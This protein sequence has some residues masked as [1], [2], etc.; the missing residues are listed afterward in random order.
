MNPISKYTVGL[1]FGLLTGLLYVVLLFLRY[2]LFASTP[3]SFGLFAF[4]SYI[5]ILLMYLF[6][7]IA[8]KKQLG[9][10]GEFKEIF[11]S[12]FIAILIAE[13]VYIIFNIIYTKFVDP[14]FWENFKVTTFSYLQKKGLTE[15]QIDQQ[16]KSFK[17]VDQ[18]M[19]PVALLKG[20][21][22]GV[23]MDSI[24]GLIFA[25]IIRKKKPVF[26]EILAKP[27]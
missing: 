18:Q 13:M 17:D 5:I 2:R 7:G 16:M 6:T 15:D 9:G 25:A 23:I 12:I 3:V 21:G 27:K 26:E 20:Y 4:V 22:F 11:Q 8:R 10:F 14:S 1:R 24:F 19:K